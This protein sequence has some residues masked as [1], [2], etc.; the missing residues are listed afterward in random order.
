VYKRLES[1]IGSLSPVSDNVNFLK[2]PKELISF[3]IA[4]FYMLILKLHFLYRDASR[5]FVSGNFTCKTVYLI[6]IAFKFDM[7]SRDVGCIEIE[8]RASLTS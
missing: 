6:A 7:Q 4:I 8:F 2:N 1:N 3:F 5:A